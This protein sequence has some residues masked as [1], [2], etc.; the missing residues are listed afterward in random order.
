[1]LTIT[2]LINSRTPIVLANILMKYKNLHFL[3]FQLNN[4]Y[5]ICSDPSIKYAAF[6][7]SLS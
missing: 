3:Q 6:T 2:H 4:V 5:K 7:I 1:M